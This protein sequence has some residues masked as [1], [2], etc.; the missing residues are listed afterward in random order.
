[1]NLVS[2]DLSATNPREWLNADSTVAD[3][4]RVIEFLTA[5]GTFR[6]P[7]LSNGLF[8]A[9]LGGDGEF[10]LTGYANIWVRDNV[11]IA[12]AH[13][14]IG[15]TD[16]AVKTM[17][18]LLDFY[19]KHRRRFTDVIAGQADHDDP[20]QRPHI[21]FSGVD[22]NE[23]PEKWSHAQ[24]DALGYWLWLTSKLA[25]AGALGLSRE[26]VEV[27]TD[28]LRYWKTIRFWE[29]ED[30][31]HWEETRKVAMSS[32]GVAVGGLREF[33]A[34]LA[35]PAG[36]VAREIAPD[37]G[38][39]TNELEQA[40]TRALEASLPHEC[41]PSGRETDRAYDSALLFL[42]YPIDLWSGGVCEEILTNV[43]THLMG[44]FG[45]RR[46]LGDSY[47]CADY[48]TLLAADA[49]TADFS[50]NLETRDR[51]LKPG[52]EAQWCIF[53]PI[54]SV[55]FGRKT[56][57]AEGDFSLQVS[58]LQRSLGQ[59][60]TAESRFGAYR[61]PESYF[62][63]NGKYV[64]NDITPLLWTQANLRLALHF[65]REALSP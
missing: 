62:C 15:E 60:T 40:G 58:H 9:A 49:R 10:A 63:E 32:V 13:W 14:V 42:M 11:H 43:R 38:E 17:R 53:D 25:I 36:Q 5:Q 41:G 21:R 34:W 16:T 30:S 12:H 2:K 54:L 50:D 45:I 27:L 20:M 59:L 35:T 31:G 7:A 51:L 55:I 44:E 48:K 52:L 8:S 4:D 61:C 39:L 18:T 33:R 1:M 46:Y 6:F 26:D 3:V 47:W 23:L 22:L 29:D 64:P 37:V 57:R 28:L 24:N 65:F 19:R 56:P